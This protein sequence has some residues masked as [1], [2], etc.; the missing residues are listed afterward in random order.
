MACTVEGG[1]T[2]A[3]CL[4]ASARLEDLISLNALSLLLV[5]V[6]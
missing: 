6:V 4:E 2:V 1:I 3:K 5:V